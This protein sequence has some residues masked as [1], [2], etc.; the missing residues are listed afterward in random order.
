MQLSVTQRKIKSRFKT[1]TESETKT[2][3]R[4]LD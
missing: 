1:D 4:K 3:T 2:A